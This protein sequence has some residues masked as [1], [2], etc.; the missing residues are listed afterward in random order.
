MSQAREFL[1]TCRTNEHLYFFVARQRNFYSTSLRRTLVLQQEIDCSFWIAFK[2][3][4][5]F[6]IL[7]RRTLHSRLYNQQSI[8]LIYSNQL[9]HLL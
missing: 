3:L 7:L 6:G 2:R 8:F 5:G 1:L 4:Q 9:L